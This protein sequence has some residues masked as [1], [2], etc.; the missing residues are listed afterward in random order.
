MNKYLLIPIVI[1]SAILISC[2]KSLNLSPQDK[3]SESTFFKN[4]EQF[5]LFSNQFYNALPTNGS[6]LGRDACSDL[7]YSWSANSISN[8]SYFPTP[9]SGLWKGSYSTI[10]NTTYLIEK[11]ISQPD[12]LDEINVYVGE[13]RF[14]RAMA[15]FNLLVDYG[16]VPIIDKVLDLDDNDLIYGKRNSREEVVTYI[17]NDLSNSIELLPLEIDIKESDKGRVNKEAAY[18]FKARVALFEGTWRKFRNQEF[19]QLLD[20]AILCSSEVMKSKSF[21]LF[22]RKDVLGDENYRYFFLLDKI[23]TNV[24]NLTKADQSEFVFANRFDRDSRPSSFSSAHTYPSVTKKFADL[25]LCIDGLPIDKSPLFEGRKKVE[26][27]YLN[28]DLRM[29]NILQKPFTRYWSF[30]PVEYTRYWNSPFEGGTIYDI[31]FG[32]ATRTGYY[33]SKF[34][35]EIAAPFG[36]DYPV[37]RLAEVLLINAE[38]LYEKNGTITNDQLDVTINKLRKRAA[39]PA[40]SNEFVMSNN[41]DMRAEIRRERTIEL[42]LEGFRFDDLRRWKT[43]EYEMPE[44]MKG[45]L[46]KDTQYSSDSRWSAIEWQMDNEGYIIVESSEKR[47]FEEKHYLLPLPTR[48]IMLN[49]NLEQNPGWD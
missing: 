7:L 19:E 36:V 21:A 44:A 42:F 26:S 2:E 22:D 5:R 34:R 25:F 4:A 48:Q 23:Q 12:L 31:N 38:A 14:F 40:L 20:E 46:W 49:P 30:A 32:N 47:R 3:Y 11:A 13:S 41:L 8:G 1:L 10:R 35:V 43:A 29:I 17:L 27:E 45:V 39:M 33:S 6:S 24:A 28:R 18:A 15:Y 37:I 9:A 16:G